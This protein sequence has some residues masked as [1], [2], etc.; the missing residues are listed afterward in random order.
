MSETLTQGKPFF[1]A[2]ETGQAWVS[3]SAYCQPHATF[4]CRA[5][6]SGAMP[7]RS[8]SWA[9]RSRDGRDEAA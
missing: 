3:C 5:G 7:W 2:C 8:G 6:A 1:E 9:G 4:S